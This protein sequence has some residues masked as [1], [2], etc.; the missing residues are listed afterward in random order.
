MYK[1]HGAMLKEDIGYIGTG[2]SEEARQMILTFLQNLDDYVPSKNS[3]PRGFPD[4]KVNNMDLD[5]LDL[6]GNE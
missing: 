2:R 4:D 5:D 3:K 1:R 6:D